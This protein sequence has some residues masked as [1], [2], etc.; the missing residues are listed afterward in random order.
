ML[1]PPDVFAEGNAGLEEARRLWRR[2]LA[3][4]R[5]EDAPYKAETNARG[6]ILLSPHKP[7]HSFAQTR[8]LRLLDDAAPDRGQSTVEFAVETPEGIKVPDVVWMSDEGIGKIPDGAEASPIMPE[9]C[10]E[11]LS[12]ANT[13]AEMDE[14]VALYLRSGAR[15]V[16]LVSTGGVVTFYDVDGK[17]T[18][19][20]VA[21]LFPGQT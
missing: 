5:F 7:Q 20:A 12:N 1:D 15:E 4:P 8:I 17:R 19:S 13:R 10:I 16:W 14:K 6:Q 3:D 21:P 2:L 11:V 18:A 9:I